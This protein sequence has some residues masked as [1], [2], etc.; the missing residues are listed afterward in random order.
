MKRLIVL[1]LLLTACGYLPQFE[2][3]TERPELF[4]GTDGITI[5]MMEHRQALY[6]EQMFDLI[7]FLK[8][9]GVHDV[10]TTYFKIVPDRDFIKFLNAETYLADGTETGELFIPIKG[11]SIRNPY[12]DEVRRHYRLQT[13]LL[14]VKTQRHSAQIFYEL[15]Y[16]Y[17]T[18]ATV[19][20]C[21]DPDIYNRNPDKPCR[22]GTKA[23][24]GGQGGPV[25]V[26]NIE[27]IM[28]PEGTGVSPMFRIMIQNLGSGQ[29]MEPGSMVKCALAET[30]N[31]SKLLAK[32]T[33]E[34][35]TLTCNNQDPS[36]P[37]RLQ[38]GMAELRCEL[39]PHMVGSRP[40]VPYTM[41]DGTFMT[42]LQI[43]LTYDYTQTGSTT[44]NIERF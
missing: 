32:V 14:P 11:K 41:E 8:N 21:I 15:C 39:E 38:Q 27:T 6:E 7:F 25:A 19:N 3:P 17:K 2:Q 22:P 28:A 12:G 18:Y 23:I 42:P 1:V 4:K 13:R 37:I 44:V 31:M 35:N 24:A 36:T 40:T 20:V 10:N 34:G 30:R 43:E 9:K 26:T 16:P 29:V 33:L 5:K